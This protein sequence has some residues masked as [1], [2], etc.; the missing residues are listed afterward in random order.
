MTRKMTAKQK[1]ND[2]LWAIANEARK[3]KKGYSNQELWLK[4]CEYF[5]YID[6]NPYMIE[7]V[8][9]YKGEPVRYS[10]TQMRPYTISGF[11]LFAGLSPLYLNRELWKT[12]N[13]N[14]NEEKK[15]VLETIRA[16]IMTQ[17]FEG[18]TVGVFN[19][20]IIMADLDLKSKTETT[21]HI[22]QEATR[23]EK[24]LLIDKVKQMMIEEATD[25]THKDVI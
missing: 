14:E 25:I 5:K 24:E 9:V 15:K 22:K 8:S 10:R 18:A 4:A 3:N 6:D 19:S 23:E 17:K 1:A 20:A 2:E 7:A 21:V 16:V 11:C 12:N 13:Q